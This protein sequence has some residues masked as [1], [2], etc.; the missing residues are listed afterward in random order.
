MNIKIFFILSVPI[1]YNYSTLNVKHLK[2]TLIMAQSDN[3]Y[4]L[5]LRV[6]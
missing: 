3:N 5:I 1:G 6:Y 2:L 4:V